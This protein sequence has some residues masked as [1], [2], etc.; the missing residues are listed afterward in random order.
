[1]DTPTPESIPTEERGLLF[2]VS[3]RTA[4]QTRPVVIMEVSIP[5]KAKATIRQGRVKSF[6]RE[7]SESS[8]D[9]LEDGFGVASLAD[10][11]AVIA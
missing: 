8:L 10:P 11:I 7:R 5:V 6:K 3:S 2:D 4:N 1:M 9:G